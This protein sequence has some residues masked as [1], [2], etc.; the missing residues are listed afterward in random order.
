[1]SIIRKGALDLAIFLLILTG[2]VGAGRLY[3]HS[4]YALPAEVQ[5]CTLEWA[6]VADEIG[7]T[8]GV[9]REVPLV[10][11]YLENGMCQEN[12]SDCTGI[13]GLSD[14]VRS[15]ALPCLEP[16][17]VSAPELVEQLRLGA[18]QFK[19]GCPGV[20]YQTADPAILK[21][22]YLAYDAGIDAAEIM[23]PDRSAFVMNR[24]DEAHKGMVYRDI[25]LE[26]VDPRKLGAWPTHLAMQSVIIGNWDKGS[27][28]RPLFWFDKLV[29][30]CRDRLAAVNASRECS[31]GVGYWREPLVDDCLVKPHPRGKASLRPRGQP[32]LGD[33]LVSQDL[34]GCH[35]GFP[36][37]DLHAS[38]GLAYL[39]APM[40]GDLVFYSDQWGDS[41]IRIE[42]EEWVVWLLHA[43][44]PLITAGAVKAG[45]LL[46]ITR[47]G[48][49]PAEFEVHYAIYDK[50][51]GGFVDPGHFIP[52][53]ADFY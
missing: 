29:L 12:P 32:V 16:G 45:D 51:A 39:Q 11:W 46:G 44:L 27:I 28:G 13:A 30:D 17:S 14:L 25:E 50:A 21:R 48:D 2:V 8:V 24:Y 43:R 38:D 18:V 35:V 52:P 22:C 3:V 36:G 20:T 33:V 6:M 1:M 9:P 34:H 19:L 42:N 15:G 41:T 23:D 40:P 49:S 47:S 31:S 53:V 10:L 7:R 37:L 5:V 4:Q 26:L